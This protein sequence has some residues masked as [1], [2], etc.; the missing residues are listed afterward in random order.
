ML[1]LDTLY[2]SMPTLDW[3]ARGGGGGGVIGDP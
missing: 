1:V 2:G 3:S